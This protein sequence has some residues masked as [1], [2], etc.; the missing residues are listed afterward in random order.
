[1]A[2]IVIGGRGLVAPQQTSPSSANSLSSS[3]AKTHLQ[4]LQ[5]ICLSHLS[6]A[7]FVL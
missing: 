1:M 7:L 3:I 2:Y 4:V 5:V 6:Y